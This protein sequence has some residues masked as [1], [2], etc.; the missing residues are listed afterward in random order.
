MPQDFDLLADLSREET[1][2]V[3]LAR[4]D[5]ALTA[6]AARGTEATQLNVLAGL[7][8][9]LAKLDQIYN[10]VDG[11]EVQAGNISISADELKLNTDTVEL[12][13]GHIRDR[14]PSVIGQL[15]RA[16]SLAVALPVEQEAILSGLVTATQFQARMDVLLSTRASEATLL[17]RASE[18]TLA[19]RASEGTQARRLGGGKKALA[20]SLSLS[21]TPYVY[22]PAAGKRIQLFW[23]TASPDPA[24][25]VFPRITVVLPTDTEPA[26]Q[27]YRV[28]GALGH[29]EFFEGAVDAPL[30]V[31]ISSNATVDGTAHIL[32]V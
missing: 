7:A 32:E 16:A 22:A 13:L 23:V 29:W 11:L 17:T 27:V 10:A 21:S 14:L 26:R 3:V 8:T 28:R 24:G 18:A 1:Q 25:G 9:Q 15:A 31:S 30:T 20:F 6:L 12:L 5:S 2:L 19:S 4:L